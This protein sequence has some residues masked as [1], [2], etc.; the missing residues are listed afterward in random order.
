MPFP[1]NGLPILDIFAV[2]I[3]ASGLVIGF[4]F[5]VIG[6]LYALRFRSQIQAAV[7]EQE[8]VWKVIEQIKRNAV[9]ERNTIDLLAQIASL[10]ENLIN[11]ERVASRTGLAKAGVVQMGASITRGKESATEAELERAH[12]H[13]ANL[14][15]KKLSEFS[16][17]SPSADRRRMAANNLIGQGLGDLDTF[18]LLRVV[19]DLGL[20]DSAMDRLKNLLWEQLRDKIRPPF[21]SSAWTGRVG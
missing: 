7:R 18:E 15:Q 2:V 13:V 20:S 4:G 11:I 5:S 16:L 21:N 19:Q 8:A 14:L 1:A 10:L 12:T 9:A 3:A 17:F 6:L